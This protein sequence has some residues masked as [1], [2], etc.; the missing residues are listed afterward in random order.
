MPY[1]TTEILPAAGQRR[2]KRRTREEKEALFA[3]IRAMKASGMTL[4]AIAYELGL[5]LATLSSWRGE[6]TEPAG[7][8][9]VAVGPAAGGAS[10]PVLVTPSG[11]RVEGLDLATL[12]QLL[13]TLS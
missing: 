12:A 8:R 9:T 4:K 11:H 2:R 6:F 3:Q 1:M 5:S 10:T 7:F 13:R